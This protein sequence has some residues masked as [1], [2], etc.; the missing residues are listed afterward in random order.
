[1]NNKL[2]VV[3][4][5]KLVTQSH[6]GLQSGWLITRI[7]ESTSRYVFVKGIKMETAAFRKQTYDEFL[8]D[9]ATG[10]VIGKDNDGQYVKNVD[11]IEELNRQVDIDAIKSVKNK[12]FCSPK[13]PLYKSNT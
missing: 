5:K 11:D 2:N 3:F 9:K 8:I 12:I 10:L 13:N 7:I 1:M 6:D 4:Y